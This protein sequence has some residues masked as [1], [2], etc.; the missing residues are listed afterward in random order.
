MLLN[1]AVFGALFRPLKPTRVKMSASPE[2]PVGLEVRT[3]LLA[4]GHSTASLHASQPI[5]NRFFGTN[6]NTEY[7]TAAQV[8]GSSPDIVKYASID[9]LSVLNVLKSKRESLEAF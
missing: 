4:K 7:P 3:T 1:C 5:S 9:S 8:L 6:N 2:G